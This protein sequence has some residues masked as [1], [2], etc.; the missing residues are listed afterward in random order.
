MLGRETEWKE[1]SLG[2]PH[3]SLG[4]ACTGPAWATYLAGSHWTK[5]WQAAWLSLC[6]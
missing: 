5:T 2:E 3:S 4:R 6:F 1:G